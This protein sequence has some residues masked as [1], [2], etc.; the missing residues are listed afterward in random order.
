[1]GKKKIIQKTDAE[2]IKE[3]SNLEKNIAEAS[4]KVSASKKIEN[5]KIFINATYNNTIITATNKNG[6]VLAWVTAGGLGFSGPKKAT[7]FAAS[8][9]VAA[10]AEKLKKIGLANVEVIVKGVG[11]GR[12][13]A[14]R[15][16]ANQGFNIVSLKD[17]TPIPHNGPKP[18]KARRI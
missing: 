18:P 16:L 10:I 17:M 11:S 7:P 3:S 15:S 5:G 9:A 8:K 13:S 2:V 1:M 14:I 6:D 12:D 4:I